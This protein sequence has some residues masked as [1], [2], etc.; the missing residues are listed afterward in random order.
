MK[1]HTFTLLCLLCIISMNVFSQQSLTGSGNGETNF[2]EAYFTRYVPTI[3]YEEID[4]SPYFND[5]WSSGTIKLRSGVELK[6]ESCKYDI[7][8]EKLMFLKDETPLYFS[9][10]EDI[11]SFTIGSSKFINLKLDN[12]NDFYEKL[13]E[14]VNFKLLKEYKCVFVEGKETDGINPATKDKYK[15]NSNYYLKNENEDLKKIKLKE[16]SVI[17]LMSDK[18][19]EIK[20]YI[21]ENKLKF[22]D[23]KDLV[24][25]FKFYSTLI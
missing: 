3:K 6:I 16:K 4:G 1:K 7:Y 9:S 21:Q 13:F 5:D 22:K 24:E 15:V 11:E 10:P 12:N 23:E 25:I 19:N 8:E 17:E 14:E 2:N 18:E 20:K